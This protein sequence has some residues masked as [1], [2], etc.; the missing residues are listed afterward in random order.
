MT[1]IKVSELKGIA[2]DYAVAV[3]EGEYIQITKDGTRY[4]VGQFSDESLYT[5]SADW[6]QGGPIIERE[7]L[8]IFF[9]KKIEEWKCWNT[10]GTI[11]GRSRSLMPLEAAMRCRVASK[12]GDSVDIPDDLLEAR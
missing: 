3:C 12:L 7:K 6:S 8:T 9:D 1:T 10:A 11:G 4:G 2:L 5:P